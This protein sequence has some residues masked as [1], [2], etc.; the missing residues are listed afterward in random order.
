MRII[1]IQVLNKGYRKMTGWLVVIRLVNFAN[2]VTVVRTIEPE[3]NDALFQRVQNGDHQAYYLIFEENW[4][5]LYSIAFRILGDSDIAKDVV[6]EVFL[7]I[8][9][10]RSKTSIKSLGAYLAQATKFGALKMIRDGKSKQHISLD[11]LDTQAEMHDELEFKEFTE[12]VKSMLDTLPEKCKAVFLLSRESQMSNQEIADEL[13][14]SKRT[15]E[16]HI[17]NALKH[18]RKELKTHLPALLVVMLSA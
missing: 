8:W 14:L 10:N 17:S 13:G 18:L 2:S 15:V 1:S 11:G 9:E 6:Q 16:T 12:E 3:E 5:L 4:E 7:T